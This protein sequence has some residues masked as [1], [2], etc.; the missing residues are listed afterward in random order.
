MD[1][2]APALS[3]IFEMM[4][5]VAWVAFALTIA[6]GIAYY[7]FLLTYYKKYLETKTGVSVKTKALRAAIVLGIALILIVVVLV[8]SPYLQGIF[9]GRVV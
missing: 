5:V 9:A 6:I 1:V 7:A 8:V 2:L 3:V 4:S